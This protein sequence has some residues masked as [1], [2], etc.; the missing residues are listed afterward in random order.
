MLTVHLAQGQQFQQ[1][2]FVVTAAGLIQTDHA[3]HALFAPAAGHGL[4]PVLHPAA[5]GD[6]QG[7]FRLTPQRKHIEGADRPRPQEAPEQR[8]GHQKVTTEAASV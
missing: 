4:G 7:Y 1:P 2:G 8:Q 3:G 6:V 5:F